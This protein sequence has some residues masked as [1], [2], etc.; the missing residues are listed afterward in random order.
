MIDSR[1]YLIFWSFHQRA[2]C[3]LVWLF[4]ERALTEVEVLVNTDELMMS[5][6]GGRSAPVATPYSNVA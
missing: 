3:S 4:E 1:A 5:T 6:G 2:E